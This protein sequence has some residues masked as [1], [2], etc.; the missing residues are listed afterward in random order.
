MGFLSGKRIL[1][2]GIA[3]KL[4]LAY[5]I[6][7][8]MYKQDAELAFTYQNDKLK[9]RVQEVAKHC[10][11][12]IVLP[13]DVSKDNNIKLLFNELAKFWPKFDGFVHAI[14][15]VPKDQLNGDYLNNINRHGFN[16]AHEIGSYSFIS[17][18]KESRKMLNTNS[19]LLTLTYLGSKIAIPNY[20]IMGSVKASLEANVK[21]IANSMGP[22][23]IRVNAISAGPVRTLASSAIANFRKMLHFCEKNT[24]I[25]RIVTIEEIGNAS[26]FLCSNLASGI[27]GEIIYV[28]GGFN[29]AL[30]NNL[31]V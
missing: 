20:N 11:S 12:E 7:Q 8:A 23:G 6:A 22:D 13:C 19:A 2:T 17:M 30:M 26:A 28:D 21:Y 14:S 25:R 4:S 3:S 5:G 31:Y 27:T 1:I 10:N 15:F 9:N 24:P 16:I 18:A 29:I